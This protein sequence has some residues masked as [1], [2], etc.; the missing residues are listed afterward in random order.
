MGNELGTSEYPRKVVTV[1]TDKKHDGNVGKQGMGHR[2]QDCQQEKQVWR[3]GKRSP[4]LVML[5][6]KSVVVI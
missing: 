3:D 6:L 4:V 2:A 1:G 5:I